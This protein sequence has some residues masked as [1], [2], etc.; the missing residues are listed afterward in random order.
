VVAGAPATGSGHDQ[1]MVA[2]VAPACYGPRSYHVP[3]PPR[4]FDA[5]REVP[6]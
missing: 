6:R 5:S 3:P 4:F 2:V 1:V